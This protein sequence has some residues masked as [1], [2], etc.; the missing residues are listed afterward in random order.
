[1]NS[2][3]QKI[4]MFLM[5]KT[6]C[7]PAES[8]GMVRQRLDTVDDRT[9]DTLIMIDYKDP[10]IALIISLVAGYFGIDRFYLGDIGMGVFKLLTAGG[11]G[12]FYIVDFFLIMGR[13]K[14]VNFDKFMTTY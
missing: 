10:T 13:A 5:N 1:M 3:E 11:C 12:I 4:T 6:K 2:R 8:M 7:F 14:T 9:L